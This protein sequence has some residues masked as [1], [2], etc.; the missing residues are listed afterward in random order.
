MLKHHATEGRTRPSACGCLCLTSLSEPTRK[1]EQAARTS[2]GKEWGRKSGARAGSKPASRSKRQ[3]KK[4]EMPG[5]WAACSWFL[6][7][8][9]SDV[10]Q[11]KAWSTPQWHPNWASP[12]F[13]KPKHYAIAKRTRPPACGCLSLTSLIFE[14]TRSQLQIAAFKPPASCFD[15]P[16]PNV[17]SDAL[18][19]L[20]AGSA[21]IF[22]GFAARL[23]DRTGNISSTYFLLYDPIR[24]SP[25][26]VSRDCK[27]DWA[28]WSVAKALSIWARH[29]AGAASK[30]AQAA[31]YARAQVGHTIEPC[32]FVYGRS[33]IGP[34]GRAGNL[35]MTGHTCSSHGL[36]SCAEGSKPSDC[37]AM[38]CCQNMLRRM[39]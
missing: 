36:S 19:L 17:F 23:P 33:A 16:A 14:P 1:E 15:L 10:R 11:R 2:S 20:Q 8:S 9:E 26:T 13:A 28:R 37:A 30:G 24:F 35:V 29:S 31:A 27:M 4:A 39:R 34:I 3:Q 21:D 18:P 25:L 38:F 5:R 12:C 32:F 6:V 7:G 22:I